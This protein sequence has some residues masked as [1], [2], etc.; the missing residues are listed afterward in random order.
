M[1]QGLLGEIH[2]DA[3]V[4]QRKNTKSVNLTFYHCR[5]QF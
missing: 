5:E 1:Y 2:V 4:D 3:E